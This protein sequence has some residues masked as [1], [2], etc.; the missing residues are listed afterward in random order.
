M[1]KRESES[2]VGG[3]ADNS[4]HGSRLP[5]LQPTH[6]EPPSGVRAQTVNAA[7]TNSITKSVSGGR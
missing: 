4:Q 6:R 1:S 7:A 5:S 2:G 3:L